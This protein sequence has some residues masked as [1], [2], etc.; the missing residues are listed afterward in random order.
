MRAELGEIPPLLY[1]PAQAAVL[2]GCWTDPAAAG[3]AA[4]CGAILPECPALGQ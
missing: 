1:P 4:L 3:E 2:L